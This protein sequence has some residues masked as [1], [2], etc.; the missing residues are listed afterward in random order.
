[1][2]PAA[3]AQGGSGLAGLTRVQPGRTKAITSSAKDF[4][5]NYDRRTYIES[6]ET[7]VLADIEGPAVINHIWLTFAEARPSWLEAEGAAHPGEIVLRMYWD[8]AAN[9]AVEVPLGDFFG[10]G[11]GLRRE[12]RSIPVQVEGGDGYNAYWQMPFFERG[13]ITVTNEGV[14]NVRSFYYQIDYTEVEA[15]PEGTAYFCAQY[16][17]E[18]PETLGEDY[19]V[20]EA[21]GQGHYVGTVMSVQ[22]RSP[23][24]FG[25]GDARIYVDGDTLPTIQ[26]TGTEDYFLS[27]WGLNE[28]LF[29]YFGVTYM[30]D[31]PSNLGV[32]ATMYRWHVDDPIRFTTSLRFELE[33]TGWMSADETETG[34][35]D[36]HVER[37]DDVATVAFWYQVGQPKSFPELPSLEGRT[38][39]DLDRA[40]EGR[41]LLENARHS[42]GRIE[43]QP[44]YGWNGDGQI[45]FFP[46]TTD[47]YLELDFEIV[48]SERAGLVLRLTH[49]PDYGRYRIL[50]DG[51]DVAELEDYPEWNPRG[52][53][54]LYAQQVEVRDLYL[55]T[56]SLTP[57][58]H[59]LRFES[60]GRNPFSAGNLLG[61]DSVRLRR[62]W[63]KKRPSLRPAP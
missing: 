26:G 13:R 33:H 37:E 41:E 24:W 58:T 57:G 21:E 17:R 44:G 29:P 10:A 60:A 27:A 46:A 45:L 4:R 39:P 62:R 53:R 1:M 16:R 56:Y 42:T 36:G 34:E 15:L 38:F 51:Q 18:F 22:S 23:Y 40:I 61:F 63:H 12:L 30:S 8:G 35:V 43:L 9:P 59:T 49:A 3:A 5:S 19:V 32:R 25:E 31:D 28:H 48:Q 20:L 2:A 14:K 47:A 52:P 55:G 6:G 7:V 11:F 54:D 50:L